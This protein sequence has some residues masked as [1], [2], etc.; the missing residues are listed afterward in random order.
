MAGSDTKKDQTP[1][2]ATTG[3]QERQHSHRLTVVEKPTNGTLEIS[4]ED[5]IRLNDFLPPDKFFS[6]SDDEAFYYNLSGIEVPKGLESMG[7]I[8]KIFLAHEL[9]HLKN[10]KFALINNAIALNNTKL[11]SAS[12][13]T[14]VLFG[15]IDQLNLTMELEVSAWNDGQPIADAISVP[16]EKYE[17]AKHI[18]LATHYYGCLTTLAQAIGNADIASAYSHD[19]VFSI[20]DP[21]MGTLRPITFAE[22]KQD[23]SDAEQL[24]I[25]YEKSV[26]A[27]KDFQTTL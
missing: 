17:L 19:R 7:L 9:G 8:G 20:Y 4:T 23:Y 22:L 27:L 14:E 25:T 16:S 26:L 15:Q 5:N 10:P 11:L 3:K 13:P 6:F 12:S 18:A 1:V 2:L 24:R 21:S